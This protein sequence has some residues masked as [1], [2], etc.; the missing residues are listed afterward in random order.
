M[1]VQDTRPWFQQWLTTTTAPHV[2]KTRFSIIKAEMASNFKLSSCK[3][4][5]MENVL[6]PGGLY[7]QK[8][9]RKMP[10]QQRCLTMNFLIFFPLDLFFL[11]GG[12]DSNYIFK[13]IGKHTSNIIK[14]VNRVKTPR[15]SRHLC[16][17]CL[18][19]CK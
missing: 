17:P 16:I 9:R 6:L 15:K 4:P 7:H 3:M 11:E 2:A 14:H 18:N 19:Y 10:C 13:L 1:G 8:S 12:E 5:C